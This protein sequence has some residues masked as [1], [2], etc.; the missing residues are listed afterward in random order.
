MYLNEEMT[1]KSQQQALLNLKRKKWLCFDWIDGRCGH[2][3]CVLLLVCLSWPADKAKTG[4]STLVMLLKNVPWLLLI[5][6]L[7]ILLKT[8]SLKMLVKLR[9]DAEL[10]ESDGNYEFQLLRW[11]CPDCC[12]IEVMNI[13]TLWLGYIIAGA[14]PLWY[15]LAPTLPQNSKNFAVPSTA[16]GYAAERRG[17]T[18]SYSWTCKQTSGNAYTITALNVKEIQTVCSR[19]SV[20]SICE[21]AIRAR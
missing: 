15:E 7:M 20:A 21:E 1:T 14:T 17:W 4:C 2:R 5:Q 11:C 13:I 8:D 9:E 6:L 19:Y 10:F 3:W 12:W 18:H 16:V